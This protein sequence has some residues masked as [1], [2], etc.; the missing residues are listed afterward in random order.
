MRS[1][2]GVGITP[3]N[4]LETPKPASSV[5][6]N[7]TLGAPLGGTT[8]GAQQGFESRASRLITPPNGVGSGGNCVSDLSEVVPAGEHAS[9][10]GCC[11]NAPAVARVAN[12]M[13]VSTIRPTR[14]RY[15]LLIVP[16]LLNDTYLSFITLNSFRFTNGPREC[17]DVRQCTENQ[18]LR[19]GSSKSQ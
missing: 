14:A 13:G 6:I 8:R 9:G 12:K 3:P 7:N 11:A 17:P 15:R 16:L 4:V 10:A 5:M 2:A 19:A 1:S 18:K